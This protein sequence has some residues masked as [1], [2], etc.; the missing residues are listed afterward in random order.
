MNSTHDKPSAAT[1]GPGPMPADPTPLVLIVEDDEGVREALCDLLASAGIDTRAF[2]CTTELLAAGHPDRPGC[3]VLDVRL[4]GGSGLDLQAR[5]AE[6]GN[7]TP[8]IFMT[9]YGDVP[10]SVQAMK[11]GAVDFLIKPFNDNDMLAAVR[12]SITQ[13]QARRQA[14]AVV[15]G[16]R[17][18][19]ATLTMRE[20]E[21][22]ESVVQGLLNKQIAFQLGLSEITIKIHR[23][24][25]MRKMRAG[26]VAELV[27]KAALLTQD[28]ADR[29]P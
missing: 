1:E 10:M 16:V 5:L 20:T 2:G 4:P 14:G 7:R 29:S 8:I 22:M 19:A 21:I 9:G 17:D 11:A 18:L 23:G 27:R 26:S 13:D 12:T 6:D 3:I 25:L 24:K 15:A 28:D